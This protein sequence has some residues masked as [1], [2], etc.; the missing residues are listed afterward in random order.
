MEVLAPDGELCAGV[1]Y[2]YEAIDAGSCLTIQ[3]TVIL[4]PFGV[5]DADIVFSAPNSEETNITVPIDGL[6]RFGYICGVSA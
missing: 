4:K 1:P 6:Y 5:N 2:P 3:W